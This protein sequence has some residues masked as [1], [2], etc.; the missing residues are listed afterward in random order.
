LIDVEYVG[1]EK[2]EETSVILGHAGFIKTVEDLYEA[3]TN[4]V[5]GIKFGLAFAEASGDC[6]VRSD[7]N[8]EGL[9][10]LAE[11][12]MMRIAAGHTFIILFKNAYPINVIKDVKNVS[13]V[14]SIFCATSNTVQVVISR[15]EHGRAVIGIA[16]GLS[17]RAIENEEDREKRR[18]L[19]RDLGYK[20]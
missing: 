1:I 19:L 2:D 6:L 10:R 14:V 12:S 4:A 5:P 17:T 7:G 9:R 16:D 15:V 11:K 18:K 20:K 3:M 13:E 8:D